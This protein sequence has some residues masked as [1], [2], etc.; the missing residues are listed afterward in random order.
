MADEPDPPRKFYQLK[1]REFERVNAD[2]PG[3][4]PPPV[5]APRDPGPQ[6][7]APGEKIDVRE[8]ARQANEGGG[9]L[10]GNAAANRPNDVHA[11][12]EAN[13]VRAKA[14]GLFGVDLGDDKARRVRI[15]N[16]WIALVLVNAPLAWIAL[17]V[18]PSN[19]MGPASAIVFVCAIGGIGMFT[20][21]WTWHNFF[22]RTER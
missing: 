11:L 2:V 17:S 4:P 15:R 21:W 12:L 5:A 14:D 7:A 20:A 13:F 9:L 18:R 10:R 6:S 19:Q 3:V 8:L 16:Y 1:P 22:L